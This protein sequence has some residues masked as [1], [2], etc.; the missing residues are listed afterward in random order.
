MSA[1]DNYKEIAEFYDAMLPP[2]AI[3][4]EFFKNH[5]QRNGVK[6]VLDCACGTGNDLLL[7][8][9]LGCYV[10]GSDLSEAML[11]V[12]K[13]KMKDT[14][15]QI[16][17]QQADFHQLENHYNS[18]FD[19]V[20]CLSNAINEFEVDAGKALQSMRSILAPG[21]IIIFDQGQTDLSIKNPLTYVP[22]VNNKDISRLFVLDYEQSIMTVQAFDFIHMEK[23]KKY[24]FNRSEFKIRIRLLADWQEILHDLDMQAEYYGDWDSAMYD[25][26]KSNRLI[27]I[28]REK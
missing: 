22:I 1:E 21:G 2:N 3:R 14:N 8:T 9:K 15:I 28:A 24:D 6:R 17:L 26:A 10:C 23:D 7:F 5:F 11:S 19:A 18:K 27:I 4:E 20:V 13:R 25:V 16:S 12:A